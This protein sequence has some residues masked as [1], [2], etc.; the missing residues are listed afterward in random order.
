MY[1]KF[2]G[3]FNDGDSFVDGYYYFILR[4]EEIFN[5]VEIGVSFGVMVYFDMM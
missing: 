1:E 2:F 3:E 5:I 4:E